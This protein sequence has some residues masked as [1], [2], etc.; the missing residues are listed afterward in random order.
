MALE[1]RVFAARPGEEEVLFYAAFTPLRWQWAE[2]MAQFLKDKGY[3]DVEVIL[4][5][6]GEPEDEDEDDDD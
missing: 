6:D 3:T 4:V 1:H 5:D 2:K